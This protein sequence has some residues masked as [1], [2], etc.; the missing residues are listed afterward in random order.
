[1]RD[2]A[3]ERLAAYK[4]PQHIFIVDRIPAGPTGKILKARLAPLA[5]RLIA[6]GKSVGLETLSD[7]QHAIDI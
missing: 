3:R 4:R 6:E 5:E 2:H 1:L 7:R